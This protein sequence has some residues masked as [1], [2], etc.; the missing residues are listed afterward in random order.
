MIKDLVK[1]IK[2]RK[3][4]R[5]LLQLPEGLKTRVVEMVRNLQDQ[6]VD[7][8]LS[9]DPCYG[10]CDIRVREAKMVGADLIVHVGHEDFGVES[11][12]PVLYYPW[13]LEAKL[14]EFDLSEKKLV[15][16][17]TVQ[18][19]D[20]LEEAKNYLEKKGKEVVFM[21]T[22]LGCKRPELP[23]ADAVVFVGTGRF[24]VLGLNAEKVYL[25]DLE[26]KELKDMSEE[27]KREKRKRA[28]RLE[29]LKDAKTVGVVMS[30]KPGQFEVVKD[31]KMLAGKTTIPIIMDEVTPEKLEGLKCDFYLNTACPRIAEDFKNMV[32]LEDL[33]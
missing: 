18:Y 6:G 1:E 30:S 27:I 11:D 21:G 32:N 29:K 13:K 4:K 16:L 12:V 31:V 3:P 2:K 10:A 9:G 24:H 22:A 20:L 33:K 5:I 15:L 19:E 28:A 26:T 25:L 14:P 23:E 8:V 17:T 7:V